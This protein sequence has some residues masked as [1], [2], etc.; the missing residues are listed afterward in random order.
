MEAPAERPVDKGARDAKGKGKGD[1]GK[2]RP[3]GKVEPKLGCAPLA[4]QVELAGMFLQKECIT[5]G[6]L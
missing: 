1:A 3:A 2:T 6:V 5:N 4:V